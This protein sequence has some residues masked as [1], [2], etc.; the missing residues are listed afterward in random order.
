MKQSLKMENFSFI[1]V[2]FIVHLL[3]SFYKLKQLKEL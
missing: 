2:K 1:K 3:Q